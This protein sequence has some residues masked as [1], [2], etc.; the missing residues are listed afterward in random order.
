VLGSFT[1]SRP[2]EI[3]EALI[4]I[5]DDSLA[6]WGGTELL[7]AMR[8]QLLVPRNLV[9]LKGLPPLRAIALENELLVIGAGATH[10]E[11]ARNRLVLSHVP[12]LASVTS[13]VGNSRV[14]SQGTIGGNLCFAEP[15][16]DLGA[17]L[18]ALDASV[19]LRSSTGIR[20]FSIS[21]FLLGPYWT[22][23]EP[24]E[25]LVDVSIPLP[26][27]TG[28]YLK[29]QFTERPSVAVA[30]VAAPESSSGPRCRIAVG[31]VSEVPLLVIGDDWADLDPAAIAAGLE[32]VPD[33][34][35]SVTYKRHLTEVMV[36]R[37]IA[38]AQ[39][40]G[41]GRS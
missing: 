33:L 17:A 21:E 38:Q 6:Y 34:T 13:R 29:Y 36:G 10:D 25:L 20:R 41:G 2:V 7:L 28:V 40:Q 11:I 14:R 3:D 22:A 27:P 35:G 23:R 8:M 12:L 16:S 4:L 37:A 9:D 26:A 24:D 18:L 19:H 32:P 31:A 39:A 30:A 1:V 15:R 5:G